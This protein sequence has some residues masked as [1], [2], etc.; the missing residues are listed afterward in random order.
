VPCLCSIQRTLASIYHLGMSKG[1]F[2]QFRGNKNLI[3]LKTALFY[4]L[5]NFLFVPISSG[6][7]DVPVPVPQSRKHGAFYLTVPVVSVSLRVQC[8]RD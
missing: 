6:S 7:I 3:P 5:A 4:C 8:K 2:V 1:C